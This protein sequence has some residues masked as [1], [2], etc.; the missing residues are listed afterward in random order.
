M[1]EKRKVKIYVAGSSHEIGRAKH[2]TRQLD[3]MMFEVVSDWP[4]LIEN[5]GFVNPENIPTEELQ[6]YA[7]HDLDNITSANIIWQLSTNEHCSLGSAFEAGFAYASRVTSDGGGS[8]ANENRSYWI[9][10]GPGQ[11]KNIFTTLADDF[12]LTDDE[13]FEA[14]VSWRADGGFHKAR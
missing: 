3:S 4:H 14:I 6:T 2:W 1:V 7:N 5:R 12:Y 13:A 10:S 11:K 9:V 8:G